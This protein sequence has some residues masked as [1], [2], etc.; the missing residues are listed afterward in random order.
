MAENT[1]VTADITYNVPNSL[2]SQSAS[3]NKTV[4][5]SY[6]GPDR[7]WV[8]PD[9]DGAAKGKFSKNSGAKLAADDGD[10]IPVPNGCTRV[11]VTVAD[12]P[13]IMAILKPEGSTITIAGQSQT[14]E[15]LPDSTTWSENAKLELGSSNIDTNDRSISYLSQE[16]ESLSRKLRDGDTI[17]ISKNISLFV[18]T[19]EMAGEVNLPGE[20]SILKGDTVLDLIE[21]AGGYSD[22]SFSEGAIFL[23]EDVAK[24]QKEGNERSAAELEDYMLRLVTKGTAENMNE[25]MLM[26]ISSLITKLR[27]DIPLGRQVVDLDYLRLKTDPALNFRLQDGDFLFIPKRPE[28]VSIIGEV[29]NPSVQRYTP[30]LSLMEYIGLSGG[31]KDSADVGNIFVVLPNGKTLIQNKRFFSKKHSLL[32][33]STIVVTRE[34]YSGMELAVVLSPI[35]SNFATSAVALAILNKDRNYIDSR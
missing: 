15:S 10:S 1:I 11:L 19:I 5:A 31:V 8:F 16:P 13:L 14:T 23:R 33:G 29:Y 18:G 22:N 12:D 34:N 6:T 27:N 25:S 17:N 20:Y 2:Y 28:S 24:L 32:P 3:S 7:C 9:T 30:S 4:T 35:L 26:P 21:R